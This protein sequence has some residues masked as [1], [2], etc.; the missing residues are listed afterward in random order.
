[1]T[2]RPTA[3][4]ALLRG[5]CPA[6][7]GAELEGLST[8]IGTLS[9]RKG[10]LSTHVWTPSVKDHPQRNILKDLT[11]RGS[12]ETASRLALGRSRQWLP[13]TSSYR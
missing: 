6:V 8:G 5:A 12:S 7:T 1:M 2:M 9:T 3:W 4:L 13:A 11:H 10:T